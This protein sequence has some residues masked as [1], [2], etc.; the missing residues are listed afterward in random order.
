MA[1]AISNRV[2]KYLSEFPPFNVLLEHELMTIAEN[3]VIQYREPQEFIFMEHA[4]PLE[5]FFLV[6]QGSVK[7]FHD[8]NED[9]LVDICD[10]GDIFGARPLL[11]TDTYQASAK[12]QEEC[13]IYAIPIHLVKNILLEN[14]A[15]SDF[16]ELGYTSD[17]PM[18][19]EQLR[20][21]RSGNQPQSQLDLQALSETAQMNPRKEV[22]K[23]LPSQSIAEAAKAMSQAKVGSIII[24]VNGTPL[25]IVTDKDL[26]EKVATGSYAITEEVQRIMSAPVLCAPPDLSVTEYMI[27][28]INHHVHHL[29]ITENGTDQSDIIGFVAD[30]DLLME[31]GFNPATLI[32]E[33]RKTQDASKLIVLRDKADVLL[34]R[35]IDQDV[36]MLYIMKMMNGVSNVLM[37]KIIES[38]IQ[39]TG[40]PPTSFAWLALGS[41][42]R[43]EQLLRTDQDHALVFEDAGNIEENEKRRSYFLQLANV[44]SSELER[45]GYE[46]DIA[47]IGAQHKDWCLSLEEWKKKFSKWIHQPEP[48]NI[49]LSNI[50][51]DFKVA[52]GD[53][54]LG[55]ELRNHL[56]Q[57]LKS[58]EVFLPFMAKN[59]LTNP[60][61]LSFFRNFVVE[62]SGEHKDEFDL[63]LRAMMPLVDAARVFA[64]EHQ[65]DS[66][67]N[68]PE[69][70]KKAASLEK[71]HHDLFLELSDAFVQLL[72]FRTRQGLKYKNS[73]RYIHISDLTK[74]ERSVLRNIFNLITDVQ[75][76]LRLR[77]HTANIHG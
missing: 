23:C 1:N 65:I 13:L 18:S 33:M 8:K 11:A 66:V 54:K 7:I 75:K 34:K 20:A 42:G 59:A 62:S 71:H 22:L 17:K 16:F 6:R 77:F 52:Y 37:C 50:F 44:V 64:L 21:L 68:T 63:K 74:L 27:L 3:V 39:Q 15:F 56:H 73:G 30:H 43:C 31:Q 53:E 57:D 49:L 61:P 46:Y 36:N 10:E 26:R 67:T 41:Q 14:K 29:C 9:L 5:H 45:Y 48:D 47:D 35:Y 25:G 28:M 2:A 51:F 72:E 76:I 19:R 58:T 24:A 55:N 69:R 38:A 60:P 4:S 12:T 70:F 40:L 32:K